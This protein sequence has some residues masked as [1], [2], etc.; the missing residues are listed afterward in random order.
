MGRARGRSVAVTENRSSEPKVLWATADADTSLFGSD[1]LSDFDAVV[2]DQLVGAW[3]FASNPPGPG[4]QTEVDSDTM[5]RLASALSR[6]TEEAAHLLAH[7]G[8]MVVRLYPLAAVVAR[9]QR[10]TW[11]GSGPDQIVSSADWW[12]ALDPRMERVGQILGRSIIVGSTGSVAHVDEPGHLP[13]PYLATSRFTAVLSPLFTQD[14]TW[15]SLA[16]NRGGE[17]VAAEREF[18]P[19][20]LLLVPSGGELSVLRERLR[21]LLELRQAQHTN[22]LLAAEE[23]AMAELGRAE[24]RLRAARAT[25][26]SR[27]LAIEALKRQVLSDSVVSQSLQYYDAATSPGTSQENA[28]AKLYASVEIIQDHLGGERAMILALGVTK[29]SVS[30]LKRLANDSSRQVRHVDA[31]PPVPITA[32]E[33]DAAIATAHELLVRLMERTYAALHEEAP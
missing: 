5:A 28:L 15:R 1:A 24:E 8:I 6:K 20:L 17:I 26:Q 10:A 18:G 33:R 4:I 29:A 3:G 11:S 30:R 9:S 14:S 32:D 13:D 22:W 2:V 21:A 27:L 19:G 25:A 16:S 23:A 31:G 7:G 12:L